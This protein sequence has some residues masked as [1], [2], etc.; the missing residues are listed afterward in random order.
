VDFGSA[1]G[2]VTALPFDR[3]ERAPRFTRRPPRE[4]IQRASL[5]IAD[6]A[7]ATVTLAVVRLAFGSNPIAP[8]F[9]GAILVVALCKLAGLYDADELRLAPST[10]DEI[11]TLLKLSGL[12]ALGIAITTPIL[13]GAQVKGVE[14]GAVWITLFVALIGGR[15]LARW[16]A[17]RACPVERCL[18]VGDRRQTER[19]RERLDAERARAIVVGALPITGVELA[20]IV[21]SEGQRVIQ[22]LVDELHVDRIIV[23]LDDGIDKE[24]SELIRLV[25]ATGVRASVVPKTLTGIGSRFAHDEVNGLCLMGVGPFGLSPTSRLL[26]R[27]FDL[28]AGVLALCVTAPVMCLIA[29]AIKLDSAGPVFFTQIRVGRDGKRFRMIKFRSMVSGADDLKDNLRALSE[30]GEGMFKIAQDPRVTRIGRALRRTSLDELPQLLNVLRGEMSL[31]GPRPL[32][33]DEDA[34][35]L[36]VDR[37]RLHLA[38]GITGPWQVLRRRVSR[39]DMI[40]IDY[41]YAAGWTLWSDVRILLRTVLHVLRLGNH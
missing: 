5:A 10:L 26:K 20:T 1:S 33:V 3:V 29:I 25:R 12:F 21:S 41:R 4:T 40:E 8:A 14:V 9:A 16:F 30:V 19:I 38:P 2:T 11:P 31:V 23:S 18:V 27:S 13:T 32:V 22:D 28:T 17:E 37:S 24:V 34:A 6:I 7:C 39:E 36:G 15:V 35:I